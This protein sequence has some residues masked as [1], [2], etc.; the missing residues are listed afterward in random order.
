MHRAGYPLG[1]LSLL[2]GHTT[3]ETT[4]EYIGVDRD[5]TGRANE[6]LDKIHEE[7]AAR[8]IADALDKFNEDENRRI[9]DKEG[10]E[11]VN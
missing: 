3:I 10:S 5:T 2:L 7:Q 11:L 8:E 9:K 4:R 6:L 1:E